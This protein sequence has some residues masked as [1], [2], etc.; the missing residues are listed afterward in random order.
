MGTLLVPNMQ[1]TAAISTICSS[2]LK[3]SI[4]YTRKLCFFIILVA[5]N[6][7]KYHSGSE[8]DS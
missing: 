2:V 3:G 1:E 6:G 5:L 4:S 7:K 8:G